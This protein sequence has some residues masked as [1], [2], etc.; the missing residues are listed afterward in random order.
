MID[1][2]DLRKF[3]TDD[4]QAYVDEMHSGG[5][6]GKGRWQEPEASR[7]CSFSHAFDSLL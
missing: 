7:H 5:E 4:L 3:Y 2:I 1:F 6:G